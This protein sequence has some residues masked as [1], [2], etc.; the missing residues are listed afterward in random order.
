MNIKKHIPNFIT[1]LNLLSGMIGIYFVLKGEIHFGA[2]FIILAAVFDFLDGFL[3]RILKVHSE[4]GKQL[5]SLADLV[6]FGVLPAFIMFQWIKDINPES[7][8]YFFALIIGIFS[9][10]RLAKFNVDTRQSDR[11]IGVPTPANALL[12]STLP[13]LYERFP[14]SFEWLA[15]PFMLLA[16]SVIMSFLLVAE[17]PLIAL[18]FKD[19][20]LSNNGFR[21]LII[22]IGVI[23]VSFFGLAGFPPL[24]ISYIA[25]S[26]LEFASQKNKKS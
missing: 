14:S 21:Y 23:C 4:I 24:I 8:L 5:D 2:Y 13:F 16:T 25:L 20:S 7:I 22:F 1:C 10:L 9:A 18:K 15:N 19:F 17:L 6:T 11:F 26:V 12:I 3:A